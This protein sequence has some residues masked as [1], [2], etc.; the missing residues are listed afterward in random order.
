MTIYQRE[1]INPPLTACS[2]SPAHIFS[3][4]TPTTSPLAA[5]GKNKSILLKIDISFP[6]SPPPAHHQPTTNTGLRYACIYH[7]CVISCMHDCVLDY[8]TLSI[9]RSLMEL[10]QFACYGRV[11]LESVPRLI[12]FPE[13]CWHV[14]WTGAVSG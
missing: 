6:C 12:A 3:R 14:L 1:R 9:P 8:C 2:F 11:K 7:S 13:S 4:G 10:P 5:H